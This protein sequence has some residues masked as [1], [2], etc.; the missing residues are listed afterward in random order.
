MNTGLRFVLVG[1]AN[2]TI[3]FAVFSGLVWLA[4]WNLVAAN[5]V[6]FCTA[7]LNS[8]VV[9]RYWVFQ[10]AAPRP[11]AQ[12]FALFAA[13]TCIAASAATLALW[14]LVQAGVPTLLAKALSVGLSMVLNFTGLSR[15][16]FAR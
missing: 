1:M 9:N 12:S 16:V 13:V 6:A 14:L 15:I 7:A 5:L 11:L 2:T 10:G 8:Y 4:S 3:D